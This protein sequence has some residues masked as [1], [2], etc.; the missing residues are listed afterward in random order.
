[1]NPFQEYREKLR[2]SLEELH[3]KSKLEADSLIVFGCSTS[4]ILGKHIGKGGSEELG[5][6][7]CAEIFDFCN[8]HQLRPAFQCCEHLNRSLV[9]DMETAKR[10]RLTRV[11]VKPQLSAGGALAVAAYNT[12]ENVCMVM[13][14]QADAGVDI[15]DT[16]IG[17]H[18][19]PVVVP[20]RPSIENRKIGEANLVMAYSRLPYV[21]G[22]RAIYEG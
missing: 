8:A 20:V 22:P 16:I 7:L 11:N 5:K 17:M 9:V 19:R 14:I 21:G 13:N 6:E 12:F 1:M 2:L 15:G 10:D 3:E 4:E 18:L